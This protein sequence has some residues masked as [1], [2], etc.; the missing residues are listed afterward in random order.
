MRNGVY[1]KSSAEKPTADEIA[2]MADSGLDISRLFTNQ[3]KMKQPLASIRVD[4]PQ[5]KLKELDQLAAEL[6]V[7]RQA[8]INSCLRRALDQH[9]LAKHGE[10]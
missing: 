8:A 6:H 1:M 5:E 2:D 9:L 3:G 10:R 7:S 4:I